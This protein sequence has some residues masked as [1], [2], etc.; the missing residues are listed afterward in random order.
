MNVIKE[1]PIF[2][3]ERHT[4]KKKTDI[5]RARETEAAK[6]LVENLVFARSHDHYS[7]YMRFYCKKHKHNRVYLR[8]LE[9]RSRLTKLTILNS[10]RFAGSTSR[11]F[12]LLLLLLHILHILNI[13]MMMILCMAAHTMPQAH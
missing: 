5:N 10:N 2:F 7:C 1:Y 6:M 12:F 9:S 13:T 4:P 3:F 8:D 11:R